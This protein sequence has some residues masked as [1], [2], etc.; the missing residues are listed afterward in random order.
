MNFDAAPSP[1]QNSQEGKTYPIVSIE[2]EFAHRYA[3]MH[4][5][6]KIGEVEIPT[7]LDG[8]SYAISDIHLKDEYKGRGLGVATYKALIEKFDKP[9]EAFGRS[10]EATNVWESLIRQGWAEKTED[11]YKSIP[12]NST[13]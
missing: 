3:I 12:R 11:G 6:K 8:D 10:D 5:G 1:R 4:D 2:Q 13:T 7:D 9:I